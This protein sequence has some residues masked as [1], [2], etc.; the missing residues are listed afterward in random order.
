MLR[1]SDFETSDG[2]DVQVYLLGSASAANG[3]DLAAAGFVSLGALK[4]NIGELNYEI[5]AGVD[6][7]RIAPWRSGAAASS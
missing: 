2:P 3:A 6:L 5:P 1:L 4:G 7:A